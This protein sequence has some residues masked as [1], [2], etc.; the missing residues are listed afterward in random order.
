MSSI[1]KSNSS[2]DSIYIADVKGFKRVVTSDKHEVKFTTVITCDEYLMEVVGYLFRRYNH[3]KSLHRL[4]V[5][6]WSGIGTI[7][8]SATES[9]GYTTKYVPIW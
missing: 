3:N 5:K 6:N 9:N 4:R 8:Y 7:L 1:F 2:L